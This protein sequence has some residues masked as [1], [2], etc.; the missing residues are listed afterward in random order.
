MDLGGVDPNVLVGYLILLG[1]VLG[2]LWRLGRWAT[3]LISLGESIVKEMGDLRRDV[4]VLQTVSM[5]HRV[6]IGFLLGKAGEPLEL[7]DE[8][9]EKVAEHERT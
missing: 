1:I 5:K 9:V 6:V 2:A 4:T 7:M 3:K 8:L